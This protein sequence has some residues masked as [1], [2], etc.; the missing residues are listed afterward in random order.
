MGTALSNWWFGLQI[1]VVYVQTEKKLHKYIPRGFYAGATVDPERWAN[2]HEIS[3][4]LWGRRVMYCWK[5]RNSMKKAENRLL[6]QR[7]FPLNSHNVSN[8]DDEP[9]FVYIIV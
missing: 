1:D 9:G 5:T 6:D 8:A 7:N 2:E 3:L 4:N